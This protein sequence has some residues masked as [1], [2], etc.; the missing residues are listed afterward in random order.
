VWAVQQKYFHSVFVMTVCPAA[1]SPCRCFRAVTSSAACCWSTS[2]FAHV[3]RLKLTWSKVGPLAER[4]LA[5]YASARRVFHRPLDTGGHMR[6]GTRR[7]QDLLRELAPDRVGGHRHDGPNRDAVVA[8]PVQ[9]IEKSGLIQHPQAAV[10]RPPGR[11]LPQFLGQ[12]PQPGAQ[13]GAVPGRPGLRPQL[14]TQAEP[15]TTN[16]MRQMPFRIR[17]AGGPDGRIG[18]WLV[19]ALLV[20]NQ[21]VHLPGSQ[22]ELILRPARLYQTSPLPSRNSRMTYRYRHPQ[23]FLDRVRCRIPAT[24]WTARC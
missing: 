13:C 21:P 5:D 7:D 17:R 18:T 16:R 6:L 3:Y 10:Y 4:I 8:I 23:E 2:S 24:G 15:V 9:L 1:T 12:M 22:L 11:V 19:S 14:V 20:E